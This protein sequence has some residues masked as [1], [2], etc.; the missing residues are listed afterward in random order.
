MSWKRAQ[1]HAESMLLNLGLGKGI[2]GRKDLRDKRVVFVDDG[3]NEYRTMCFTIAAKIVRRRGA[4]VDTVK[5]EP[6]EVPHA[7][8]LDLGKPAG[9]KPGRSPGALRRSLR[10]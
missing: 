5:P 9:P 3:T 4:E 7:K 8:V 2:K 10:E 1:I 6:G